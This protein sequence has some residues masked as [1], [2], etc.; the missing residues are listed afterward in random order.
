[1]PRAHKLLFGRP[2]WIGLL[3]CAIFLGQT[4]SQEASPDHRIRPYTVNPSFWQYDGRPLLLLGGSDDD[5]LFQW[6]EPAL[7]AQL[8]RLRAAGGNYV[9]NTMSSRDAGNAQPFARATDGRYDLDRW[10]PDYW[11]R[12]DRFLR[13]TAE[14]DIVV[15]IELWDPWDLYADEWTR[16]P[17]SPANNVNYTSDATHLATAYQ[18]PQ[19][20]DGTSYGAPHDLLR[21]PPALRNDRGVLAHQQRFVEAVLTRSLPYAHV[22]YCITNEI[23]PQYAPE[24]GWYWAR[25][26]RERAVAAGRPVL[27][28]EMYWTFDFQHAQHR[29]SFDHPDVYDFFE[30]SQNSAIRDPEA[31]WRNLQFARERLASHPRPINHTKTYGADTGPVWAGTERDAL[32]RF[33]RNLIGGA[34]SSRFHRPPAGIGAS[35]VVLRHLR[36]ARLLGES[37]DFFRS[38]PDAAHR[39]LSGRSPNE[40]YLAFIEGEQFAVYFPDGGVVSLTPGAGAWTLRWLD[41]AEGRWS[42]TR[43][44]DGGA[45]IELRASSAGHWVAVLQAARDDGE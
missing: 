35:D 8:D 36:S 33:W 44:V 24:W 37:F 20:R 10:N 27:V 41:I 21:T 28:T 26:V 14:R 42:D 43:S 31:H 16:S 3:L 34:A 30:A 25:F 5:N 9:R 7:R 29:A 2:E 40:A 4:S 6:D 11:E 45:P 22:L 19:Y 13:M 12:F 23:H 17:W 32:E 1:M 38:T 18:A 15:Q 39:R